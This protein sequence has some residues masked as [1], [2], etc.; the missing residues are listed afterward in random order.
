MRVR[1]D[2][3]ARPAD[4]VDL[5]AVTGGAKRTG[6]ARWDPNEPGVL[7]LPFDRE[8][9]PAEEAAVVL[10]LQSP[11]DDEATWRA[12]AAAWLS[13]ANPSVVQNTEHLR[14]LTRLMLNLLDR[15]SG[16]DD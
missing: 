9:T 14:T 12:S 8:L 4:D 1:I 11:S 5:S 2:K 10:R 16:Q 15:P 13:V 7:I 6:P 3:L